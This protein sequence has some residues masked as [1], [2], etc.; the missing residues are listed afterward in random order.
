MQYC[1][2]QYMVDSGLVN[3]AIALKNDFPDIVSIGFGY[4]PAQVRET[5]QCLC[6]CR[7][8]WMNWRAHIGESW[9][10]YVFSCLRSFR[11]VYDQTSFMLIA[12]QLTHYL[13]VR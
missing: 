9:P 7:M 1:E 10:I 3:D 12:V 2:Y 4:V 8:R 11:A 6:T 5:G 13:F